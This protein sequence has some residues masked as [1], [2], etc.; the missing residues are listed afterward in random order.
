M[1]KILTRKKYSKK[2]KKAT[3][4]EYQQYLLMSKLSILILY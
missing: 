1:N 3:I 2:K 4:F